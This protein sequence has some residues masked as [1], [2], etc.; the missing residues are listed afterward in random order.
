MN[1]KIE[2][3]ISRLSAIRRGR[4]YYHFAEETGEWYRVKVSDLRDLSRML[5]DG[6]P[7]A[8]SHWCAGVGGAPVSTRVRRRIEGR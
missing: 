1:A 4:H 7:D 3:A 8:Y 6:M 2:P 5:L